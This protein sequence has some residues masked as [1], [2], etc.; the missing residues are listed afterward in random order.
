LVALVALISSLVR[1]IS[2]GEARRY[3][4]GFHG[5]SGAREEIRNSERVL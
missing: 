3:K 5:K 1:M 4:D 2:A